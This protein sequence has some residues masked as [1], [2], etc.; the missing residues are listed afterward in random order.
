MNFENIFKDKE[1]DHSDDGMTC[2]HHE[3]K[4]DDVMNPD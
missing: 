1:E 4:E 3:L 2:S